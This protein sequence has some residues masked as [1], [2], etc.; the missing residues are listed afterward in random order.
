[1]KHCKGNCGK[2]IAFFQDYCKEC[3]DRLSLRD[4]VIDNIKHDLDFY[5]LSN[6]IRKKEK[7]G[8]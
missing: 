6:G 5:P 1:M 7:N 2:T 3:H 8:N 4:K